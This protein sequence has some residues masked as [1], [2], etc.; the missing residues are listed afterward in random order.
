MVNPKFKLWKSERDN[1]YYFRLQAENGELNLHSEGYT[2]K[3]VR[4][5]EL[6]LLEYMLHLNKITNEKYQG[7]MNFILYSEHIITK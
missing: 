5:T 4:K 2:A 7:T 6:N 3:S 1:Q